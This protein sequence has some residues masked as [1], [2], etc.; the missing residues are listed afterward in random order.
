M[1][2]VYRYCLFSVFSFLLVCSCTDK[3]SSFQFSSPME[4]YSP[5]GMHYVSVV[6]KLLYHKEDRF[7]VFYG[8]PITHRA[9]GVR[10][11]M[12][13]CFEDEAYNLRAYYEL[14]FVHCDFQDAH[15]AQL[16][17]V[18]VPDIHV[19]FKNELSND[20]RI[21]SDLCAGKY[22]EGKYVIIRAT[23]VGIPF[24]PNIYLR[25]GNR[26]VNEK[27]KERIATFLHSRFHTQNQITNYYTSCSHD[28]IEHRTLEEICYKPI[29]LVIDLKGQK[30]RFSLVKK[31]V[32]NDPWRLY[33][34][35]T[36][37]GE[38]QD[39]STKLPMLRLD[40]GC[41]IGQ[42][43]GDETCDCLDQLHDS[44]FVLAKEG[45]GL[46]VHMPTH[47]GRGFGSAPKAETEIYKQGGRGRVHETEPLDTIAAAEHLYHS[48]HIDMRT[49][50][51][52]AKLL[53][54]LG[55]DRV[56]MYT[57][58]RNKVS[59]LQNMGIETTRIPTDTEKESCAEHLQ[60]KKNHKAYYGS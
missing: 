38:D 43:Y 12:F 53:Q 18:D 54:R 48:E 20:Y 56:Q 45:C 8:G 59:S 36:Y 26:I 34:I 5:E 37:S 47:D 31:V 50:D 3:H 22:S 9:N 4:I 23:D 52:A 11:V 27:D 41:L 33:Y 7:S 29:P 14:A 42:V 15:E 32:W 46:I 58:N 28:E 25:D 17:F 6:E 40:S 30:Q 44:L 24:Y 57:D 51:G 2:R 16:L 55:I 19:K 35:I 10:W 60:A 1:K 13:A 21:F 49:F 39:A